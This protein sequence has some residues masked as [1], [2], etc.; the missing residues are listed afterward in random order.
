MT[1]TSSSLRPARTLK[2]PARTRKYD[3]APASLGSY[4]AQGAMG[5][6]AMMFIFWLAG[7]GF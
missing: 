1:P 3:N 5:L 2:A 6:G 7:F 4:L